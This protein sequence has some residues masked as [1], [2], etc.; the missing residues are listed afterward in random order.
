MKILERKTI[1]RDGE[2]VAFPNLAWIDENTLACFFRHAKERQKEW[3]SAT[4]IDPTAKDVFILSHDN[5]KTFESNFHIVIDDDM[6]EQDPCA[7]V[8]KSGRIIVTCFRWQLVDEGSGESYWGKELYTRYGRTR[9]GFWDSYNIGFNVNISDDKGKTWRSLPVLM[10]EGYVIGSAV[11]GNIT[12]MPDGTLLMPFYGVKKPGDLA[13]CGL[14]RSIDQ[15]E[16]WAFFSE[17]ACDPEKNF[18]EPNLF[19]TKSGRLIT[20]IRTQTDFYKPNV[21]FDDTYLNMHITIS[22]D[23]GKT[24]G[25]P[26][27]IP[28]IFASS[29]FHVLQLENGRTFVSYG[30]RRKPFGIRAKICGPELEDLD[31]A[32]ELILCDDAPN[33]DLGYP[34]AVQLKDYSILVSYYISGTDSIR[35]IEGLILEV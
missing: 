16:T 23:N 32:P 10:P 27:E 5:G 33:G 28:S 25:H 15:G 2:Y 26:I 1:Y 24:F 19:R 21:K 12:E 34:H 9:K 7:T 3:G 14:V 13:S 4:H 8:L 31:S 17:S 35:K 30:Y 6:S 18:L 29:P 11:R 22:E 20:L